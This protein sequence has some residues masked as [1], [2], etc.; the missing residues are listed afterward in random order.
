[1]FGDRFAALVLPVSAISRESRP[2]RPADGLKP[3]DFR[4]R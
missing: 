3:S 2:G 1:L 4:G